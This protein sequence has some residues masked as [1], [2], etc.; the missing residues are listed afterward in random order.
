MVVKIQNYKDA[1]NVKK[2]YV[3]CHHIS[4][5]MLLNGDNQALAKTLATLSALAEQ[6]NKE[7][8]S[9]YHKLY[10]KLLEQLKD[11]DS[12]PFDQ[13][14]LREQLSDLDQKIKQKENITSVPIKLKE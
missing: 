1:F 3:E 14:D 9:G 11:L 2:D 5:D 13:E 8:W 10:K 6:V 7:R 12:F 4:R